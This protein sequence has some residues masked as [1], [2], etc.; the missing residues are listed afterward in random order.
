MYDN[1]INPERLLAERTPSW[2]V[3]DCRFNLDD[4]EQGEQAFRAGHLPGAHYLNL[5]YHLSG[6]RTGGNG[7]HPLPDGQRLAV[8]LGSLGISADTQVI[9]Y[10]DA[11]GIYAARAWWLLRWLGHENVAVL[12]GGLP[13]YLQAGGTLDIQRPKQHTQRFVMRSSQV[14]SAELAEVLDNLTSQQFQLV[15]ARAPQRF[16]GHGETMDPVGGHIPGALNRFFRDNL[17]Q[18]GRFKDPAQLRNE[19]QALLGNDTDATR[20]IHQCGS[21]VSACVNLL[22]MEIAGLPGSRLYPGSWS[23]WCMDSNRPVAHE[24]A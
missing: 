7:R 15:D 24:P 11:D 9:T 3:L 1:A 22:A 4:P 21:G 17:D 14:Q 2:V 18:D 8:C 12:D 6:T 16:L 23:E 13:A 5:D 19:W 20:V 10:D